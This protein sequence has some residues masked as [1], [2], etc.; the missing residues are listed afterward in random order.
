MKTYSFDE[1]DNYPK[2][3]PGRE[4]GRWT[5]PFSGVEHQE[6]DYSFQGIRDV[7]ILE[8]GKVISN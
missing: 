6:C 8:N 2:E 1:T 3:T 7:P 5:D 4:I